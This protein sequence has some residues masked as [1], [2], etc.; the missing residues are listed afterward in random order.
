MHIPLVDCKPLYWLLWP[1]VRTSDTVVFYHLSMFLW[2]VALNRGRRREIFSSSETVM[3]M[4]RG[5]SIAKCCTCS[6]LIS[7]HFNCK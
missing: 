4:F 2:H 7:H 6:G 1:S 3:L 5:V